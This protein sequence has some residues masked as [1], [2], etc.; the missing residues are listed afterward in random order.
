MHLS[1]IN[2]YPVKSLKGIGLRQ[3]LVEDRGLRFDRR[4]M[5]VDST[6]KFITQRDFPI[7]ATVEIHID[8]AS[9]T[10]AYNGGRISVPAEPENGNW[11]R[12]KI[13]KSSV[14]ALE[15]PKEINEWFSDVLKTECRLVLM[16]NESRRM[17]NPYY[18][19]RRFKDTV[20]FADG[21]PF[22]LLG[23]GSLEDLNSRLERPVPM[24]RFRP[25]FV[26]SAS[27]AFAEDGWKKIRI[28]PTVFH[29][30][31]PCG[32][33]IITTVDQGAGEK[34]GAE[35]LKTLSTFRK[36]RGKVL[37]GQNLIAEESGGVVRIGDEVEVLETK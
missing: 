7:M 26:V 3:A 31:K 4:W 15:Y 32:R 30:V 12:V 28:G 23:E 29:V 16:P 11:R 2:I 8:E 6:G 14:K 19:V 10:A 5:L 1:E 34:N 9:L 35:P 18:A 20:S 22:L 27:G 24:N 37:F 25:N 21:Y 36:K 17:V 33:C 13:W